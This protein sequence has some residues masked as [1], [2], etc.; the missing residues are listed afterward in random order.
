MGP[1]LSV[2]VTDLYAS[3]KSFCETVGERPMRCKRLLAD[4]QR[5]GVVAVS[6][7]GLRCAEGIGIK[8]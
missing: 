4:L 7:Y 1:D 2:I 6:Q 8:S 5:H 3:Y